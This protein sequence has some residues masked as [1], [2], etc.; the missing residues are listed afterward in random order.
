MPGRGGPLCN[1]RP[2]GAWKHVGLERAAIGIEL[3]F[4]ITGF[5]E[6]NDLLVRVNHDNFGD[7]ANQNQ[8]F[9][10]RCASP[11]VLRED[12]TARRAQLGE[13]LLILAASRCAV[14][15]KRLFS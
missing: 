2:G 3:D 9:R 15:V 1:W 10:H 5:R 11:P 13:F 12:S 8:F 7:Y 14:R 4:E 6:P